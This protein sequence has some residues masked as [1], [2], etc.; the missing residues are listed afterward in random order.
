MRAIK[1]VLIIFVGALVVNFLRDDRT[2]H[3]A[4]SLRFSNGER[5]DMYDWAGAATLAI[6]FWGIYRLNLKREDE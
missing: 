3:I 2:F 6:I 1:L 4:K 5:I